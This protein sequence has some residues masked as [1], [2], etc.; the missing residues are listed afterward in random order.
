VSENLEI[1]EAD[2]VGP[3]MA[4]LTERAR[5]FVR[6]VIEYPTTAK[7][8]LMDRA[9]FNGDRNTLKVGAHRL[10]HSAKVLAAL[11]EE[12]RGRLRYGGFVGVARLVAMASD[13]KHP[14]H[15]KA[16]E[17][18][19]DRAGFGATTKIE[20]EDKTPRN[21]LDDVRAIRELC[22]LLNIDP[23]QLLGANAAPAMKVIEH[24]E[25]GDG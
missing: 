9:G 17:A 18:L 13:P 5:A 19:A 20:V 22:A 15:F 24:Q 3:A 14:Q 1:P 23:A 12:T 21:P 16:C 25:A 6:L 4:E 8:R 10:M 7:W 11:D 2:D